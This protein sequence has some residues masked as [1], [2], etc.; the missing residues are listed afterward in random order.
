MDSQFFIQNYLNPKSNISDNCYQ[1]EAMTVALYCT[2]NDFK[3]S[4]QN[5]EQYF[6][7]SQTNTYRQTDEFIILVVQIF[8]H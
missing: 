5:L 7:I 4:Y 2:I 6:L 3:L 1:G 8:R